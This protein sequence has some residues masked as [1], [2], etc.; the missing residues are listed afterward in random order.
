MGGKSN[1]K[2][3]YKELAL[4]GVLS[5]KSV[6]IIIDS[7]AFGDE[8]ENLIAEINKLISVVKNSSIYIMT[9]ES[10]EYLICCAKLG[11]D[12][13]RVTETYNFCDADKFVTWGRY[14][15]ELS[16]EV[17]DFCKLH[18]IKYSKKLYPE[19]IK[20]GI[21]YYNSIK[22][23]GVSDEFFYNEQRYTSVRI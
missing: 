17:L 14:F 6:Y 5:N 22:I 4:N 19:I 13:S 15:T 12:D 1:V 8:I 16:S 3:H 20:Y 9:P 2:K 11:F 7:S 23:N 21:K 10:F 18:N